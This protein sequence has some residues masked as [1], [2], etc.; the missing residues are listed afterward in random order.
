MVKSMDSSLHTYIQVCLINVSILKNKQTDLKFLFFSFKRY[1]FLFIQTKARLCQDMIQG[2]L[3]DLH[4]VLNN[5]NLSSQSSYSYKALFRGLLTL[6]D[7]K[8]C[9]KKKKKEHLT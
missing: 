6:K 7:W 4:L 8:I 9:L 1:H 2:I 5:K 3:P